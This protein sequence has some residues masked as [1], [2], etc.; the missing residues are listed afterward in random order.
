MSA[1]TVEIVFEWMTKNF[2]YVHPDTAGMLIL[3]KGKASD[4]KCRDYIVNN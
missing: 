4:S 1:R 3:E 2:V